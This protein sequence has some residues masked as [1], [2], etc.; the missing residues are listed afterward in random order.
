MD[1]KLILAIVL[2]FL[3]FKLIFE[4]SGTFRDPIGGI[5]GKKIT[6]F[7]ETSQKL[8]RPNSNIDWKAIRKV[9]QTPPKD[10]EWFYVFQSGI[11]FTVQSQI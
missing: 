8:L 4:E 11:R 1:L 7:L 5:S 2:C 10:H 6:T 9:S 3:S